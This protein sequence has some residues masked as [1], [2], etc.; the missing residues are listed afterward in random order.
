[1]SISAPGSFCSVSI[2][3]WLTTSELPHPRKVSHVVLVNLSLDPAMLFPPSFQVGG[4]RGGRGGRL[5]FAGFDFRQGR[6]ELA[7]R[8]IHEEKPISTTFFF[9]RSSSGLSPFLTFIFSSI[10]A[11][12]SANL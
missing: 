9:A 11:F 4:R 7:L 8:P 10:Q 6:E 12:F 5:R 2:V 1:M 3:D